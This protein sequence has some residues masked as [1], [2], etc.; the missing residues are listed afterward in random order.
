[1]MGDVKQYR[2]KHIVEAMRWTGVEVAAL[3]EWHELK[4]RTDMCWTSFGAPFVL[5]GDE[6][7]AVSSGEWL[8]WS[9]GDFLV[10]GDEEF[11]ETYEP[12]EETA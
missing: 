10:M 9:H 5:M 2:C 4:T 11:R 6:R 12:D 8:V 7:H 1:M 3:T